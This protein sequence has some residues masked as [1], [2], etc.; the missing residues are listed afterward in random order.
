MPKVTIYKQGGAYRIKVDGIDK[1]VGV[2][3]LR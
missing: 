3:R 1:S 2:I